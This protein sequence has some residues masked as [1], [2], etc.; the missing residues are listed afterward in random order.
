MCNVN[1]AC[2]YI[3]DCLERATKHVTITDDMDGSKT[4]LTLCSKHATETN[5]YSLQRETVTV[6]DLFE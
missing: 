4:R 5:K 2:E 3:N 6:K 1:M